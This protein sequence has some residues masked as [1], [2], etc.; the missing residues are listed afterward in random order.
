[1]FI[2]SSRKE[3]FIGSVVLLPQSP[4]HKSIKLLALSWH[5]RCTRWSAPFPFPSS[6]CP[7]SLATTLYDGSTHRIGGAV[8]LLCL[9]L[10][11]LA[12]HAGYAKVPQWAVFYILIQTLEPSLDL[13]TFC[14]RRIPAIPEPWSLRLK[15]HRLKASLGYTARSCWKKTKE[16]KRNL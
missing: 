13:R 3:H 5:Q 7:P 15:D 14:G 10:F 16:R 9:S 1:M 11:P 4:F 12:G 2:P 8:C 6:C